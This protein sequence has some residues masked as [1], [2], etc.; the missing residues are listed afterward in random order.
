[1]HLEILIVAQIVKKPSTFF[2][3]NPKFR[4]RVHKS[5]PLVPLLRQI[6]AVQTLHPVS[7]WSISMLSSYL[8]Q[9]FPGSLFSSCGMCTERLLEFLPS[10]AV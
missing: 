10:L 7:F 3:W 9:G 2:L 1:M 5:T 6:N 4:Y 8:R